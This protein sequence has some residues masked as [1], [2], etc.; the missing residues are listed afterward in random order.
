MFVPPHTVLA[1][2]RVRYVGE[3]VALVVAESAEAAAEAADLIVVEY[4]DLPFVTGTAAAVAPGA[5][6]IWEEAPDNKRLLFRARRQGRGG[7][8]VRRGRRASWRRRS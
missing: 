6:V 4:E 3:G 5:P 8:R 2:G 1:V 7:C